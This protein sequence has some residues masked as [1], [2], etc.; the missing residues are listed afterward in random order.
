MCLKLI[1]EC[2]ELIGKRNQISVIS[3]ELN[4]N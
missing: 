3:K 2:K 1:S 4:S